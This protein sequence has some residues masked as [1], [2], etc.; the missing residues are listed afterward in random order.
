MTTDARTISWTGDALRL[1]DRSA[2]PARIEHLEVRDVDAIA[3][4]VAA[5]ATETGVLDVSAGVTPESRPHL[6]KGVPD[7][8]AHL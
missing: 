5:L 3:R 4:L 2:L 1:P 8:P 6:R 7:R